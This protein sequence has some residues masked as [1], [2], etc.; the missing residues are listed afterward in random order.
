MKL[1]TKLDTHNLIMSVW[2]VA[3]ETSRDLTVRR[4][5]RYSICCVITCGMLFVKSKWNLL[6]SFM[7]SSTIKNTAIT[8]YNRKPYDNDNRAWARFLSLARSKLRLCSAIH[9]AGYFSNLAWDW[10]SIV[11]VYSEQDTEIGPRCV[12]GL[13]Q[14]YVIFPTM[15]PKLKFILS[16]WVVIKRKFK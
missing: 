12:C 16:T 15:I 9:R 7:I 3:F 8:T 2:F 10:P 11:W 14:I 4:F 5:M 13:D 6:Q 1:K